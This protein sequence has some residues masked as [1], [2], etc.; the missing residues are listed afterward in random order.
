MA[1]QDDILVRVITGDGTWR[2]LKQSGKVHNGCLPIPHAQKI[3]SAQ[4]KSQNKFADFFI[5]EGLFILNLYQ[6]DS[7]PILLFG[8]TRKAA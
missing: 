4:L 3:R 7:E 5:L 1:R 2:T 8:S 6:L